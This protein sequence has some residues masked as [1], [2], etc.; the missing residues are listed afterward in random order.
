MIIEVALTLAYTF[1]FIALIYRWRFFSFEGLQRKEVSLLFIL[2]IAAGVM[3]TF[4]YTYYYT[5]RSEA[6][7]FKFFDDS[8][9]IFE[10]LYVNPLHYLQLVLGINSD[11]AH[12]EVYTQ[13]TSFWA[14]QTDAYRSFT[15]TDNHNYFNSHRIVTQFNAFIRLFSFGY[16]GVHIVFINFLSLIGLTALYRAL[17]PF[18]YAHRLWLIAVVFLLPSVWLWS[19][20][21]LKESFVFWGMG[22]FIYHFLNSAEKGFTVWR[23]VYIF[24]AL[25]L[26]VFVKYY[27]A[28]VIIPAAFAYFIVKR[29]Q[30]RKPFL[31]Y[32]STYALVVLSALI[33]SSFSPAVPSPFKVLSE[34]QKELIKEG[35]GGYYFLRNEGG[36]KEILYFPPDSDIKKEMLDTSRQI[37]LINSGLTAYKFKNGEITT[38]KVFINDTAATDLYYYEVYAQPTSGS[39]I[40]IKPLGGDI[41]SFITALPQAFINGLFRPHIL[42]VRSLMMLPA[43]IENLVLILFVILCFVKGRIKQEE[44]PI[45]Y[46]LFFISL[47]LTTVIGLTTPVLGA[48]VRYKAPVLPLLFAGLLIILRTYLLRSSKKVNS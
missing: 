28:V 31:A 42:E 44:K 8:A 5:E 2:K 23:T 22:L 36:Q 7:I 40:N 39:Y 9:Y 48:I 19:S 25:L 14:L 26:L 15:G 46:M 20:G 37:F 32:F 10:A 6:D 12:L 27:L 35:Y 4:I 43:A 17:Y 34:K 18:I 13:N 3:L 24:L 45:L 47:S 30:I 1:L 33:V 38:E 41:R 16:F 29:W 21:V 11:A